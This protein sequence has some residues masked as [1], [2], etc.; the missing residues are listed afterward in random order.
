MQEVHHKLLIL[1]SGPA[2]LTAAIYAARVGV[3]TADAD[4]TALAQAPETWQE[5][6][7]RLTG[8]DVTLC[9]KCRKGHLVIKEDLP[10]H[11][12]LFPVRS[13]ARSP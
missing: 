5:L 2:G 13:T 12:R 4:D 9:P 10:V 6:L 11:R 7:R 3:E 8:K 1:G